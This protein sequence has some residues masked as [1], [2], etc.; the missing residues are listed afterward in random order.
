VRCDKVPGPHAIMLQPPPRW[1]S[2]FFLASRVAFLDVI[3][4]QSPLTSASLQK[5][6][7]QFR[8]ES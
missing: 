3:S 6:K 1:S 8:Y 5:K 7:N 2:F 4:C